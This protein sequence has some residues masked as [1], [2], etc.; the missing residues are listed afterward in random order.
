MHGSIHSG[1]IIETF[2]T[3]NVV[4]YLLFTSHSEHHDN[5]SHGDC[6]QR[7]QLRS[8]DRDGQVGRTISCNHCTLT[9]RDYL[10]ADHLG[11]HCPNVIVTC[12]RCNQPMK[13]EQLIT[14]Q[15]TVCKSDPV[16][17]EFAEYGCTWKG[18]R[19]DL[20]THLDI[21]WRAHC[22]DM[23]KS[24]QKSM[25][26]LKR[27]QKRLS[28][29]IDS[30]KERITTLESAATRTVFSNVAITVGQI[31]W[32]IDNDDRFISNEFYYDRPCYKGQLCVDFSE[33]YISVYN[34][35]VYGKYD[36]EVAWPF[37]GNITIEIVN[38]NGGENYQRQIWYTEE[39][40]LR[41]RKMS[42]DSY[43]TGIFGF[44]KF[45][46]IDALDNLKDEDSDNFVLLISKVEYLK[47][48]D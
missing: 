43:Q 30:L 46:E 34:R 22:A 33:G 37:Q 5:D 12:G 40:P 24:H 18:E 4:N 38:E 7:M 47:N 36:D 10:M 8:D 39:T 31:E 23:N 41:Y 28:N 44:E 20:N 26:Q 9:V 35:F 3:I 6:S 29:D 19:R 21:S 32:R 27:R 48:N 16:E 17:C 13:R 25:T 14:H 15:N 11:H 2:I 1:S 45:I 42:Q